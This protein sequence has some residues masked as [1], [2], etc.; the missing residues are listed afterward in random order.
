MHCCLKN[1]RRLRL[2]FICC[3]VLAKSTCLK[4]ES[5]LSV[6]LQNSRLLQ[7]LPSP[8][9]VL[10]ALSTYSHQSRCFAFELTS[11]AAKY[12]NTAQT[13]PEPRCMP[14]NPL[15]QKSGAV[16]CAYNTWRIAAAAAGKLQSAWRKHRRMQALKSPALSSQGEQVC[17]CRVDP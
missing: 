9:T 2:D 14:A 13:V 8:L 7:M 1:A 12:H 10:H 16:T 11:E 4:L 3:V 5:E 6:Q 15:L 17:V